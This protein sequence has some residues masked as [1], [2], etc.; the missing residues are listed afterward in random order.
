MTPL[1]PEAL[2]AELAATLPGSEALNRLVG[3]LCL[4]DT[5]TLIGFGAAE[6]A[7]LARLS[8][9]ILRR[10]GLARQE[11]TGALLDELASVLRPLSE[12]PAKPAA[13]LRRLFSR[14]EP[15]AMD[16]ESLGSAL[17]RGFGRLRCHQEAVR[18]GDRRLAELRAEALEDYAALTRRRLAAEQATAEL[19][20]LLA[21]PNPPL[22]PAELRR[23]RDLLLQRRQ[24]MLTTAT[25]ARQAF[26]MIDLLLKEHRQLTEQIDRA[27]L[28]ALPAFRQALAEAASKK[29][30]AL[31][32]AAMA[33]LEATRQALLRAV[34]ETR[35]L[36]RDHP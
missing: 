3:E 6:E 29:K 10:C 17:D 4:D 15:E 14:P 8:G 9:E 36:R 34:D 7:N 25:A 26:Q 31:R 33:D 5:R 20:A 18:Q 32:D 11:D 16:Y 27:F 30:Q 23:A 1:T 13:G 21:S 2:E 22:D 28:A 12:A 19:D 24:S 35:A